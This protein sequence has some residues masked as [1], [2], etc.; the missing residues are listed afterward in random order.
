[1]LAL[2]S[3]LL[4]FPAIASV[5][6]RE[7]DLL[8]ELGNKHYCPLCEFAPTYNRVPVTRAGRNGNDEKSAPIRAARTFP[9]D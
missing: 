9:R 8:P 4:S 1:M 3:L 5:T 7:I 2:V 6:G